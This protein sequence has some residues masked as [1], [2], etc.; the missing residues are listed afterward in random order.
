[1]AGEILTGG[2]LLVLARYGELYV[3]FIKAAKEFL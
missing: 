3:Y 1:M 2:L